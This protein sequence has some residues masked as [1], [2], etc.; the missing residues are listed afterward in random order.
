MLGGLLSSSNR[1][2]QL[3]A[4]STKRQMGRAETLHILEVEAEG[5]FLPP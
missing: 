2:A 4:G 5:P 1:L 3:T